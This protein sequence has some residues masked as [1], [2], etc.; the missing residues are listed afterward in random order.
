M[1]LRIEPEIGGV[2]VVLVGDFTPAIFTP[3]W[4]A[5]HGLLPKSAADGAEGSVVHPRAT[6]FTFD[7]LVLNVTNDHFSVE[8][9]QAPYV[10]VCD[11]VVRVFREFL[12]H[13]PLKAFGIN[14]IVH[15][16]VR[17]HAEMD[18]IGRTLAPVEPWGAWRRVLELDGQHGGMTSLR[19]SQVKIEGRPPEDR[20]NITVEPSNP[21]IGRGRAGVY[22]QVNDH[23][24]MDD[25]GPGTGERLME[26][27]ES[28]F[29]TSLERGDGIVDHVMSL[30]EE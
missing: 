14:R 11:L 22:V 7:G 25:T 16:P 8:T 24:T 29:G 3:A 21:I 6:A 28:G 23:Y 1:P 20:I 19:M 15:F 27:L 18:R 12:P 5:L 13:M 30:A 10:R 4:F 9:S 17:N 2:S 26:I